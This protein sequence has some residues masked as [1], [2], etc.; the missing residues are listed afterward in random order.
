MA[1]SQIS[2]ITWNST[3]YDLYDA[4]AIHTAYT[5]PT[6]STQAAGLFKIGR[7][8]TGHV[9]IGDAFTI[10]SIPASLKNPNAVKIQGAGEDVASYDGSA[11]KT[12]NF[13]AS[14]TAGA[15]EITDG[16]T[17]KT[18]QLAGKFTDT[19]YTHPTTTAVTAGLYKIGKDSS[20]H[21]VIGDSFTIPTIPAS[22]KNPNAVTI[23]GGG[24]TVSTYDGSA[25]KTFNFKAST[26]AGALEI[27]DGT[28][29]KTVQ[30]AGKFTDTVYTHPAYT[31]TAA[32][33][34]KIGCDSTGHVVIGDSFTIPT[35]PTSLKNPNSVTFKA[36]SDTVSSYDGSAA[37]T[38][39]I[40]ASTTAGAFTI[41]DGS[42]TKTVQLAGTFTDNNTWKANSSSSEGYV[43]SGSGQAN[44]VWKT[45]ASGNPAWRDDANTTYSA[46]TT[47]AAGLMSA[48]DKTK[49]DALST[50]DI[51]SLA[52]T[53]TAANTF[54]AS[55]TV[56]SSST[57]GTI[58]I[59][60]GGLVA[61]G[62]I[63]GSAVYNA[64]W[65]DLADCIPVDD[66]ANLEYGYA[67][68]FDGEHY[69]KSTKYMDDGL[70][71]I[72]SD[73]AGFVMGAKNSGKE[74]QVAVA[75][76]ALAYVDREYKPGTPLTCTCC[77]MLTEMHKQN[78]MENPEKIVATYWKPES[79]DEWGSEDRKVI[80][81][82][83]HWV[84]VK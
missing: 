79:A 31:A 34:Y 52:N 49:L 33:L 57:T 41:S 11:A 44:K 39:T 67:Y 14:T 2:N 63:K 53:F 61:A 81:N 56:T 45:D 8:S 5:H 68:C 54:S 9:V 15:L 43:S 17:T 78:K 46:A 75:G 20:G 19:V 38:F 76:F 32:G 55:S 58:T 22:L 82:G 12:F 37:K 28:T 36:G 25:A 71:G 29:T 3:T 27:T 66:E 59:P 42:T 65:N 62:G 74:M 24:A 80:V 70:I 1:N 72:H 83:R 21:V 73:T 16:T 51:R 4:S 48:A 13:K 84:K 7:D 10:P 30:L 40:A 23:Q 50:A 47:S 35:I 18:V 69:Y 6:Y 26:T 64:V 77:G 60:N